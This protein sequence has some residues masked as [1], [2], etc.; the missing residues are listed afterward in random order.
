MQY[1]KKTTEINEQSKKVS[2]TALNSAIVT[3]IRDK[4]SVFETDLGQMI[5]DMIQ[6]VYVATVDV[7]KA[8]QGNSE[9][10]INNFHQKL[11]TFKIEN[12]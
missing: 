1:R 4:L 11:E 9:H 10:L 8:M 2:L 6:D 12:V 7:N 5:D 3:T